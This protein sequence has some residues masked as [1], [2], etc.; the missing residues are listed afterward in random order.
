MKY[1]NPDW[2]E[3]IKKFKQHYKTAK[4]GINNKNKNRKSRKKIT[5]VGFDITN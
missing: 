4:G 1:H 3:S 5:E 2:S